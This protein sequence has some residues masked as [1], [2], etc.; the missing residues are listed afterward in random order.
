MEGVFAGGDVSTGP[1]YVV[2][3]IAAGQKAAR[4]ISRYLKGEP[5]TAVNDSKKP[6]KL[7]DD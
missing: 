7:T 2:D 5:M 4:S 3:A 6:E 1:A